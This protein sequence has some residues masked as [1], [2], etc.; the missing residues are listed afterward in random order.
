MTQW[1]IVG[2]ICYTNRSFCYTKNIHEYLFPII[3]KS[4]HD[5]DRSS[6]QFINKIGD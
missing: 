4:I 5:Y 6:Y 1:A 2:L 3:R